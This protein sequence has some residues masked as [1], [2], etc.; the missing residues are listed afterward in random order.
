MS[1]KKEAICFFFIYRFGVK[2]KLK[3]KERFYI[4]LEIKKLVKKNKVCENKIITLNSSLFK[5]IY[6][7]KVIKI[8]NTQP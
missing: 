5:L 6:I 1:R 7:S 3:F 4:D 2:Q 8:K